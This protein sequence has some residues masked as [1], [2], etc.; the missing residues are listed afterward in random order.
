[1]SDWDRSGEGEAETGLRF[2][3]F[4]EALE[5]EEAFEEALDEKS[6]KA[7]VCSTDSS[8]SYVFS[9]DG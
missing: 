7:S 4:L 8:G 2:F 5:V 3:L 9:F 1:M 6:A